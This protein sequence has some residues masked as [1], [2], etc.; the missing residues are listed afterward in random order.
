MQITGY[1]ERGAVSSL[2]YEIAYSRS[3]ENVLTRLLARAVFPFAPACLLDVVS[4]DVLVEQSLS[5]FG[6]S[7][8][9]LLLSTK[10]GRC[11][12]FLEAKV[13]PLQS[14]VWSLESEY[15]RFS[16]GLSDKVSSS[17][18]FTQLYHKVRLVNGLRRGGIEELQSGLRFPP[19]STRL[20]RKIGH[21]G[22]VLRAVDRLLPHLQKVLYLALTPDNPRSS[23]A[24]FDGTLATSRP[25][26]YSEWDTADYGFV[27][28]CEVEEFCRQESLVNTA[29]VL[30][31][32]RGQIY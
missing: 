25:P 26:G 11:C 28:W 2:L 16:E 3:P 31:F 21:N 1:S 24:F 10:G 12:V 19:S 7:D 18:L 30:E 9:I 20:V 13:K 6:D 29:R 32:N 22:V 4:A 5:D 27:C 14:V 15:Q 23:R 8:A 17:N